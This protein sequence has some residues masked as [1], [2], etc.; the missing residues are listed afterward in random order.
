MAGDSDDQ[1][2]FVRAI[3]RA[4]DS[5]SARHLDKITLSSTRFR[6]TNIID[7]QLSRHTHQN[8]QRYVEAQRFF[9]NQAIGALRKWGMIVTPRSG[10]SAKSSTRK[11]LA[12][13]G[14]DQCWSIRQKVALPG[15]RDDQRQCIVAFLY[16][17]ET[18]IE[19]A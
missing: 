7:V 3:C 13:H 10:Y 6:R 5:W 9:G 12:P 18:R 14:L 19:P 17:A 1:R 8:D 2:Q 15:H 11:A 16:L 4:M